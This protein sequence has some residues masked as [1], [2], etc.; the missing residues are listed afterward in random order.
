[1]LSESESYCEK[2]FEQTFERDETGRFI[3]NIPYKENV[4]HL[5]E[6]REIALRRLY[7]IERRLNKDEQLKQQYHSFMQQYLALGHMTKIRESENESRIVCYL[8]HHAV[9]KNVLQPRSRSCLMR[10]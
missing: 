4:Q 9:I 10:A 6:S 1:M 8:P 3:V 2:Y 5:G 7:A